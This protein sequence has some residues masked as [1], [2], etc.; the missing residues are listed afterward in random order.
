MGRTVLCLFLALL[1]S[2]LGQDSSKAWLEKGV[3]EFK[4]AHYPEAVEAFQKAVDL[5]P[6]EVTPHL[7]LGTAWM[8]QFVPGVDDSENSA[9]AAKAES[10][11]KLVLQLAPDNKVALSSLASLAFTRAQGISDL[12]EK[13]RQLDEAGSWYKA[14]T[15]V[16]PRNKEA[17][18]SLGVIVW[19]KAYAA[20]RGARSRLGMRPEDPGPIPNAAV[21]QGLK[22]DYDS[23]VDEG[24]SDL[25]KAIDL[26]PSYDDAMAYL[27]LLYRER[28][29]LR[30]TPEEYREDIKKADEWLQK[31][32]D[33]RRQ[34]SGSVAA[35]PKP[36]TPERPRN[37]RSRV[38]YTLLIKRVEPVYPAAALAARVEGSVRLSIVIGADGKVGEIQVVSGHPLLIQAATDAVRQWVY[39]PTLLNGIPIEVITTVDV[40][41]SL[42]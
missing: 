19:T 28:A 10:E 13:L 31:A 1:P 6:N 34:K 21:R 4:R 8:S 24:L 22:I 9:A 29:D 38:E 26:D 16:D 23:V 42:P 36:T 18:Y 37:V 30:D 17:W 12:G 32:I 7:Y 25:E 35:P 33:T 5:S 11:F 40:K 14:L 39:Q 20:I 2:L 15:A 41:F 27:N 3:A